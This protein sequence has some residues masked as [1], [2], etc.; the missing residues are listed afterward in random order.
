MKAKRN[1]K[2]KHIQQKI[3][4]DF[5]GSIIRFNQKGNKKIII[6]GLFSFLK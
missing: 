5:M 1:M 2:K 4:I 6:N 3:Q